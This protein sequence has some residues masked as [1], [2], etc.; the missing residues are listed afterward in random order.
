[1]IAPDQKAPVADAFSEEVA[2]RFARGEEAEGSASGF[3]TYV[4]G[5]GPEIVREDQVRRLRGDLFSH[6]KWNLHYT[7][8]GRPETARPS[9]G[10]WTASEPDNLKLERRQLRLK[11]YTSE[12]KTLVAPPPLSPEEAREAARRHE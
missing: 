2:E 11:E 9:V 8:T 3:G 4:P 1:M 10:A 7:A 12:G 6:I 5:R